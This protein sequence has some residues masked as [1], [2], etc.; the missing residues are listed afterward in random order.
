M[1]RADAHRRRRA[2]V[3]KG[4]GSL[5]GEKAALSRIKTSQPKP[6]Q[7]AAAAVRGSRAGACGVRERARAGVEAQ[8]AR[9]QIR[10]LVPF[11]QRCAKGGACG[12]VGRNAGNVRSRLCAAWKLPRSANAT[13]AECHAK[14][15]S[16]MP[17]RPRATGGGCRQPRRRLPSAARGKRCERELA[18][19]GNDAA[20]HGAKAGAHAHGADA[21]ASRPVWKLD[22][23][24]GRFFFS[25]VTWE[26]RGQASCNKGAISGFSAT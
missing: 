8:E 4:C 2:S 3:G 10:R 25:K 20:R 16:G 26:D 23:R 21:P 7:A 14:R 13:A 11:A 24:R 22:L 17:N 5:R 19:N 12:H 9:P 18:G 1:A 6:S 15:G